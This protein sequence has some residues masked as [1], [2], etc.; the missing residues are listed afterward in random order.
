[1]PQ[2][3]EDVKVDKEQVK[4]AKMLVDSMSKQFVDIEMKDNYQDAIRGMIKA[5]IDGKVKGSWSHSSPG[6]NLGGTIDCLY[7]D[8]NNAWIA[9]V[10]T[11]SDNPSVPIGERF[12][13]RATDNGVNGVVQG[14]SI[15]A[16]LWAGFTAL[17]NQQAQATGKPSVGFINPAI[18]A[19]GKGASYNSGFHDITVGNI[20]S[21]SSHTGF[22]AVPGYDLCTGWGTPTG[23][24]LLYTLALPSSCKSRRELTLPSAAR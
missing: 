6:Q 21:S 2:L 1:M 4:M 19:L 16:P 22:P 11:S 13:F 12:M 10:L 9:G 17:I 18:Y 20:N 7:V 14:T 24:N 23:S 15:S 3:L 8:G 5:K